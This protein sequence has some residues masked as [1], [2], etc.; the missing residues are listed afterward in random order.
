MKK[1]KK[2]HLTYPTVEASYDEIKQIIEDNPDKILED[3]EI[4]ELCIKKNIKNI[5]EV[6]FASKIF[7][8]NLENKISN[9]N[10]NNT[11]DTLDIL[12]TYRSI[13]KNLLDEIYEKEG[14]VRNNI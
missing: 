11:L 5:S 1:T 3:F 7:F 14:D 4:L 6:I 12:L 9:N 8:N 2:Y 10:N 13:L